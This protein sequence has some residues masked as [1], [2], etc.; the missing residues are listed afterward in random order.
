MFQCSSTTTWDG[1]KEW[2]H[3][4]AHAVLEHIQISQGSKGPRLPFIFICYF[5]IV[6]LL[7]NCIWETSSAPCRWLCELG[8]LPPHCT[9]RLHTRSLVVLLLH[10]W[11]AHLFSTLHSK[12]S[13]LFVQGQQRAQ[14]GDLG[15]GGM[16]RTS[17]N[18]VHR[19]EALSEGIRSA[20]P[21]A[22]SYMRW[23]ADTSCDKQHDRVR[24]KAFP[25]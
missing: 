2:T 11:H 19:T 7:P 23:P 20:C 3:V 17:L 1:I 15:G 5:N 6:L 25:S 16:R 14:A 21:R 8:L 9:L 13:I 22:H 18:I 4:H 10:L 24:A 12:V